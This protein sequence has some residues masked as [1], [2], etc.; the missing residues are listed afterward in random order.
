MLS[1]A[2]F[3]AYRPD[4]GRWLSKD[5]VGKG[6]DSVANLYTFVLLDPLYK[7]DPLGQSY[8]FVDANRSAGGT[9]GMSAMYCVSGRN[10][11]RDCAVKRLRL[12]DDA[13]VEQEKTLK[14]FLRR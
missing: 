11:C 14:L 9:Y 10:I 1:L 13:G 5:P 6:T 2:W 12:E 7:T 4:T 8:Q 3:R